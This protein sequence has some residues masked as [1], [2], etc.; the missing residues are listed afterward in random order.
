MIDETLTQTE[1]IGPI[2]YLVI[3][4]PDGRITDDGLPLLL[5][6]VQRQ[7]IHVLDLEFVTRLDNGDVR[8]VGVTELPNPAGANLAIFDGASSGL[9]DD[10]DVASVGEFIEPGAVAAVVIYENSW[11]TQLSAALARGNAQILAGGR[12]PVDQVALALDEAEA[13]S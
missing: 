10:D 6:L 13:R 2:D 7:I 12:I 4:F 9:L 5:D 1:T 3:E 11:A 8:L